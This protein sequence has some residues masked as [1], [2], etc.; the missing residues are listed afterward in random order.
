MA[1]LYQQFKNMINEG[2]TK[3]H[4]QK[5]LHE[6]GELK[7][8]TTDYMTVIG[9]FTDQKTKEFGESVQKIETLVPK[10][11]IDLYNALTSVIMRSKDDDFWPSIKSLENILKG[12]KPIPALP[13]ENTSSNYTQVITDVQVSP[14]WYR[15]SAESAQGTLAEINNGVLKFQN[16]ILL[17]KSLNE[18]VGA[19]NTS[20]KA[21]IEENTKIIQ[22]LEKVNMK[23]LTKDFAQ[24]VIKLSEALES[25]IAGR[26]LAVIKNDLSSRWIY[27]KGLTYLLFVAES[28]ADK[29][30]IPAREVLLMHYQVVSRAEVDGIV[31]IYKKGTQN[32][33]GPNPPAPVANDFPQKMMGA[34]KAHLEAV[35]SFST[36]GVETD[37]LYSDETLKEENLLKA[38]KRTLEE[39][40]VAV[41]RTRLQKAMARLKQT[42]S[43]S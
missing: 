11:R 41:P 15:Q 36:S 20:D 31:A 39:I 6:K 21:S 9:A 19:F 7:G 26:T 8:Y 28:I 3:G 35:E 43:R 22:Q 14:E 12:E 5:A 4:F 23:E 34:I 25:S 17:L 16:Q 38:G 24:C 30:N 32:A 37:N 33:L 29:K 18:S 2:K 40:P 10:M 1:D 13:G 27:L 42:L